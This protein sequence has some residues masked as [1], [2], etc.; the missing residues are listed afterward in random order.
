MDQPLR[1]PSLYFEDLKVGDVFLGGSIVLS[2]E[3]IISFARDY[4]PQ[5]MHL[6]PKWAASGPHGCVIASGFQTAALAFRLFYDLGVLDESNII[7]IGIDELRWHAPV[8]AGMRLRSK[9]TLMDKRESRS[10]PDRGIANWQFTL[11]D[12]EDTVLVSYTDMSIVRK[13]SPDAG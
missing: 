11:I 10:K 12:D 7:G 2:E 1:R 4:D 3:Q 5:P 13:K 9:V 8:K 6:D